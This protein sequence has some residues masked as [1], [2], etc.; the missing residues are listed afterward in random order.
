M[1]YTDN[2]ITYLTTNSDIFT[3]GYGWKGICDEFAVVL[4]SFERAMGI[5]ARYLIGQI[6]GGGAHAWAEV[7]VNGRWV[8]ADATWNAFDNPRGY[9]FSY[10]SVKIYTQSNDNK[11]NSTSTDSA[12]GSNINGR[13]NPLLDWDYIIYYDGPNSYIMEA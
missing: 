12:D 7:F 10:S 5:P 9:P 11:H 2:D 6:S 1:T 8:H 4:I 3:L 13:L